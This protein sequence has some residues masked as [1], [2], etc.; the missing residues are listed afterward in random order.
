MKP[1]SP[2]NV[3]NSGSLFLGAAWYPEQWERQV[4][5]EDV[6]LMKELGMNVARV[7]EFAWSSLEP[8]EGKYTTGWLRDVQDR[9]SVV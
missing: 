2:T 8:K 4:W 6:R 9:K 7:T 5:D 1:H 3:L